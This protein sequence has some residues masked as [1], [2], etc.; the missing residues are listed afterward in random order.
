M[1][2]TIR[3]LGSFSAVRPLDLTAYLRTRGWR[4][5]ETN[6]TR[7]AVW[8][9]GAYEVLVPLDAAAPAFARRI[10]DV[11]RLLC[12][13]EGRSQLEVYRD[14]ITA[15]FD[16]VRIRAIDSD[17]EDGT[18]PIEAGVTLVERARD[19]LLA[20][21]CSAHQAR[22][23]FHTRKPTPAIEYLRRAR[24]GQTEHG[25]FVVALHAPV[26]PELQMTLS[27]IERADPYERKVTTTLM[28]G[29]EAARGAAHA[30]AA[31]G[32]LKPFEDAVRNGV[33]ANLCDALTGL[34][35][36]AQCE[37]LSVG[38]SWA[39]VRPAPALTTAPVLIAR[40]ILPV[41]QEAS[42]LF[43]QRH[44][45]VEIELVGYVTELC[46]EEGE[47]LG[48]ATVIGNGGGGPRRIRLTDLPPEDYE[49][50]LEAHRAERKIRAVGE[51]R[52]DGR[53]WVLRRARDIESI[54]D[55]D[56]GS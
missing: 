2:A 10:A 9:M 30:A 19:V 41:L 51:L 7:S 25:S 17:F 8:E 39:A 53:S 11:F 50:V 45:E 24:L 18:I 35:G 42:R 29:V 34:H 43:K 49:V 32:D 47:L 31:S 3:D 28:S 4:Q 16:I 37:A 12:E 14:I 21:A 27:P 54:P 15:S 33:S 36:I 52:K 46:R 40:D 26:P 22:S 38:V 55:E 48:T 20:A 56:G 1:K 5:V 44:P 6:G 23:V 13:A